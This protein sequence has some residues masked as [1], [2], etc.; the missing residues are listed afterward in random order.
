MRNVATAK[1]CFV[2]LSFTGVVGWVW[3]YLVYPQSKGFDKKCCL[4]TIW[5]WESPGNRTIDLPYET[6]HCS[7]KKTNDGTIK[8]LLYSG[9]AVFGKEIS[10][11]SQYFS[12]VEKGLKGGVRVEETLATFVRPGSDVCEITTFIIMFFIIRYWQFKQP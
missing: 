9:K 10:A 5:Y 11:R 8:H 3:G 1:D 4:R 12:V 7:G 2:L 6:N